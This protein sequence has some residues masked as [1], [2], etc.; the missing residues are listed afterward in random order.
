MHVFIAWQAASRKVFNAPVQLLYILSFPEKRLR[1]VDNYIG[2]TK[3]ITDAL[4]KTFLSR[5]DS[6][7]VTQ[8]SVKF[9]QGREETTVIIE[10]SPN[11]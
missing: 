9:I 1:D 5:D 2:G 10:R 4:K 3:L 11:V 7:W 8:I 6:E